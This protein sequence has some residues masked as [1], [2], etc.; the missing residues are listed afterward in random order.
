MCQFLDFNNWSK[1]VIH[2]KK[3]NIESNYEFD[4]VELFV[5]L[6][7]PFNQFH[8]NIQA[9]FKLISKIAKQNLNRNLGEITAMHGLY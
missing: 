6:I 4:R 5:D 1:N 3:F 2:W 9:M 7:L 8:K